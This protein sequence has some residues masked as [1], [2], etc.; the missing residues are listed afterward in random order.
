MPM[1]C[2][3]VEPSVTIEMIVLI[4][5]KLQ[6]HHVR[7]LHRKLVCADPH[8]DATPGRSMLYATYTSK[9]G[10]QPHITPSN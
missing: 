2:S 6:L 8:D 3:S 7:P 10:I 1:P 4:M 5:I 9:N